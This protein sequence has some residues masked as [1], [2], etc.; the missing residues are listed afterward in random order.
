MGSFPEKFF[1]KLRPF[2]LSV[3]K[4]QTCGV[5]SDKVFA[6]FT[7]IREFCVLVAVCAIGDDLPYSLCG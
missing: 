5:P 4:F 2:E 3:K 7:D 6:S 1:V